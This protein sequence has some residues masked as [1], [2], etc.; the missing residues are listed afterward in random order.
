MA[1]SD[2]Q[3]RNAKPT[4][5]EWKLTDGRGLYLLIKPNGSK[6]W[7][8]KYRVAGGKEKKAAY[9]A[10]P[11]VSLKHARELADADRTLLARRIDPSNAKRSAK[12]DEAIRAT[13]TFGLVAKEYI[14]KITR[15]GRSVATIEK[16]EWLLTH[17]PQAFQSRPVSDLSPQEVLAVL[18][19]VEKRG[20]LETAKRLRAFASR[21]FRFAI[22]TARASQDPALVL[23]G[24][25]ISPT[26]KHH[27]AILVPDQIGA[28]MRAIDGF[29]GQPATRY[30]L[31]FSAHVFQRPG[32]IRH[33]EWREIDLDLAVWAIPAAK[34]K[35]RKDHIVPLS[36]QAVA[37]L[38]EMKPLSGRGRYVF[39][40]IRTPLRPMSEN[41]VNG[42]LRRLGYSGD[43]MTAHGFRA[44]ASTTLNESG[45]FSADAIERA[46]SHRDKDAMRGTYH[47]GPHHT[48]RVAM[49]QW[50]SDFLDQQAATQA[51]SAP[52]VIRTPAPLKVA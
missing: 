30:A 8:F 20:K 44:T 25:L 26:A 52:A 11:D 36:T 14:E 33:A 38:S 5:K 37:I 24:A 31:K 51:M 17:F 9:G 1:L 46:L 18:K 29:S 21:V 39:P 3:I 19:A 23:R 15:E 10:Y 42:A 27:A 41:T 49:A 32:E 50:W 4:D 22:Q 16:G 35:M 43:E 28:L 2:T 34:M 12:L 7:R 45:M 47:R 40:S 48:E 13:N 6:L